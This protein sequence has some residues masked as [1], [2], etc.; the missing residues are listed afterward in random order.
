MTFNKTLEQFAEVHHEITGDR[1][2]VP[3]RARLGNPTLPSGADRINVPLSETDQAGMVYLHDDNGQYA[4]MA[5]NDGFLDLKRVIYGDY[6][7]VQPGKP[8]RIVRYGGSAQAEWRYGVE[9][10]AAEPV[11]ISRL[12]WGLLQPTN[13][14]SMKAMISKAVYANDALVLDMETDDWTAF[15]PSD[16]NMAVAIRVDLDPAGGG[17]FDYVI[18]TE[19]LHIDFPTHEL[20]LAA[21]HY[22]PADDPTLN[23]CGWIRLI[24]GMTAILRETNI[25]VAPELLNKGGG[26][27]DAA[28]VT[29]DPATPSNWDGNVDPGNVDNALDQL[30]QRVDDIENFPVTPWITNSNV[31]NLL[32][33]ADNVTIGSATAGGKLFVDGDADEVQ[34]QVQGNGTQTALLAVFENSAGD[35]QVA[36]ANNGAVVIN[37]QGNDADTRIE[38]DTD[39]ELFHVDASQDAIGIGVGTPNSKAKFQIDSTTKGFLPPRMTATQRDAISSPPDGLIIY[40][41]DASKMNVYESSAWRE[42][43]SGMTKLVSRTTLGGSS[44][45]INISSIP[46]TYALLRLVLELRSDRAGTSLDNAYIRFNADSTAANYYSYGYNIATTTPAFQNTIQRL[47]ATATGIEVALAS[48][49]ATSPSGYRSALIVDIYGYTDS[50]LPRRVAWT[51]YNQITNATGN[52]A[53]IQGGGLWTNTSAAINQIT[54]LPVVGSNWVAGTAYSL[55]AAA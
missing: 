37:E 30:A 13:P 3:Y 26:I 24:N 55:Y 28:D 20:A 23:R 46:G 18:G 53:L 35:D 32:T 43:A 31:V 17:A 9:I 40:N 25:F 12:D 48:T 22:P 51:G 14:P 19:Y 36:I 5:L 44:A 41:T 7:E 49:A 38:G 34:L 29:Y 6:V 2:R 47:G 39:A 8:D 10:Q 4:G 52:L 16:P 33:D 42:I 1:L 27:S 50:S 54:I 11:D 15:I 45:T 21:G